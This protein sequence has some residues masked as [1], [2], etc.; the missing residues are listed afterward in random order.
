MRMCNFISKIFFLILTF[1]YKQEDDTPNPEHTPP[2]TQ[3]H[4][5]NKSCNDK[6]LPL[7]WCEISHA[8][9]EQ[10]PQVQLQILAWC[11]FS[12]Y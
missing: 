12:R 1:F 4:S 2:H 7:V 3:T 11:V 10:L 6:H 5:Q 9:Q 8:Q